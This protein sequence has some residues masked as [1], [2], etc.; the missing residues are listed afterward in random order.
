MHLYEDENPA[1]PPS[2]QNKMFNH[3]LAII[4]KVKNPSST[5]ALINTAL[6]E[7]CVAL[8]DPLIGE[9]SL[10]LNEQINLNGK[11]F[12]ESTKRH[13]HTVQSIRVS[14][15]FQQPDVTAIA[16]GSRATEYIG[17]LFPTS[18]GPYFI[19]PGSASLTG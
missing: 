13:E 9:P 6:I 12:N 2:H 5:P 7:G 15:I 18:S 16:I 19:V 4:F 17:I 1:L 10:P 3:R 11:S 14:G 8:P